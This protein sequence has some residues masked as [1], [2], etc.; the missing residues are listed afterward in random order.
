MIAWLP[1]PARANG[2]RCE[3]LAARA[4]T[5]RSRSM[6]AAA[7]ASRMMIGHG[8]RSA[9]FSVAV[10]HGRCARRPA[11]NWS[12]QTSR[13]TRLPRSRVWL[14]HKVHRGPDRASTPSARGSRTRGSGAS[15]VL[16]LSRDSWPAPTGGP[17]PLP[18]A[19]ARVDVRKLAPLP[20]PA[21]SPTGAAHGGRRQVSCAGWTTWWGSRRRS[22]PSDSSAL[23]GCGVRGCELSVRAERTIVCGLVCTAREARSGRKTDAVEGVVS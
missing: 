10:G 9:A 18:P 20:E 1:P 16:R 23:E 14:S 6:C 21:G 17:K 4:T 8:R 12:S 11:E 7:G 15:Q 2:W 22:C 19:T 5:S 13:L 3:I